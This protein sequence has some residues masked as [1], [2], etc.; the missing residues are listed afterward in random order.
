MAKR[1]KKKVG[2]ASKARIVIVTPTIEELLQNS[3]N[4]KEASY[5]ADIESSNL[6]KACRLD[7]DIRL[8]T[9]ARC[10]SAFEMDTVI[11]HATPQIIDKLSSLSLL[12]TLKKGEVEVCTIN[13]EDLLFFTF[14]HMENERVLQPF[15][16][17]SF[18]MQDKAPSHA[19]ILMIK[20]YRDFCNQFLKIHGH[21]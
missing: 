20:A 3:N 5:K 16:P 18:A 19:T 13:L 4:P 7:K 17:L 12:R 9:Y 10:T 8:S 11:F 6:S 2:K 15:Q 1:S 14:H 21:E